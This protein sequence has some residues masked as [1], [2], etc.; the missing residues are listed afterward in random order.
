[1]PMSPARFSNPAA[2]S[3]HFR[4]KGFGVSTVSYLKKMSK[5][6]GYDALAW[7]VEKTNIAALEMY[8]KTGN[9]PNYIAAN[10]LCGPNREW[11]PDM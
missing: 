1:M 2:T 11:R 3:P 9:F 5:L 8:A 10:E 6:M 4:R 7:G